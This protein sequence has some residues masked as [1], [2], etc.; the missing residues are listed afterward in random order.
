M[1]PEM[2]KI[3]KVRTI[4]FSAFALIAA[5]VWYF[6]IYETEEDKIRNTFDTLIRCTS[7]NG[8]KG[9]IDEVADVRGIERVF[10]P[11]IELKG[12]PYASGKYKAKEL[13]LRFMQGRKMLNTL[14]LTVHD[15]QITISPDKT[16]AETEFT[17]YARG[18]GGKAGSGFR[19]AFDCSA[20]LTKNVENKWVFQTLSGKPVV[21]RTQSE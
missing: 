15:L 20:K 1:T 9:M 11:E 7:K 14:R 12:I 16:S 17:L 13:A 18:N 6:F 4:L 21:M 10:A 5:A 8:N 19:E 2:K 3:W